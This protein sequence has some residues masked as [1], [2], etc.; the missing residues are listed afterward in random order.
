MP[1]LDQRLIAV[2]RR[3]RSEVHAD[4]GSDHGLLLASLL[5]SGRINY[6]IAIENKQ[7]P[8][9]NSKR[10]LAGM[11][12]EGR[13]GDGLEVLQCGEADSLSICGMGAENMIAILKRYP[14]RIPTKLVLQPNSR[15]ELVRRWAWDAGFWLVA[16]QVVRTTGK[17]TV[18][19]FERAQAEGEQRD[20]AYD[21]IDLDCGFAFGPLLL[22]EGSSEL[23][24]DLLEEERWWSQFSDLQPRAQRRLMLIRKVAALASRT[25]SS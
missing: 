21:K 6:G 17:Y 10:T 2:T 22:S 15:A 8:W 1:K 3:I 16:E 23:A 18:L 24:S 9:E 5:G 20:P 11:A 12:A 13:F 25:V 7:Q 14:D 19:S 4:I